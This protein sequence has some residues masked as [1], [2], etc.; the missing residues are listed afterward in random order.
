LCI[1]DLADLKKLLTEYP[2]CGKAEEGS[3][4]AAVLPADNEMLLGSYAEYQ[5]VESAIKIHF[6]KSLKL[7]FVKLLALAGIYCS[8]EQITDFVKMKLQRWRNGA[9]PFVVEKIAK[10]QGFESELYPEEIKIH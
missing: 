10:I 1:T 3:R 9:K 4:L 7:D 8:P 5:K 2:D 6:P